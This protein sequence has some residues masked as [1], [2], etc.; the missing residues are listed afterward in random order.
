MI[1]KTLSHGVKAL[2]FSTWISVFVAFLIV[3]ITAFFVT[4]PALLEDPIENQLSKISGLSVD[5]SKITFDFEQ[6]GLVLKVHD[7][8]I[9]SLEQQVIAS[10]DSLRWKINLF[11]FRDD[12]YHPSNVNLN[13]LTIYP[14]VNKGQD[15][16]SIQDIKQLASAE[17][18]RML[19]FFQSFSI[20]KT[21]I[22]H[23]QVFEIAPMVF[24]KN[25]SNILLTVSGQRLDLDFPNALPSKVDI[26]ATFSLTQISSEQS[27]N[28]PLSINYHKLPVIE[29]NLK[30]FVEQGDDMVE[31]LG[32]LSQI[33]T[34]EV[35]QYIP[36]QSLDSDTHAWIQRGFIS[37]NLQDIELQFKKNLS[38]D[39]PVEMQFNAQ[40]KESELL[41]NADWDNLK[42]L[43]ASINTDGKKIVVT[44]N[45]TQLN[46]MQL[47]DIIV[48]ILDMSQPELDVEVI[49][50][51]NAT[52]EKFIQ[53]LR[54]AP[55]SNNI[56]ETLDQFTLTGK[57][58]G[59]LKL[60]LPLDERVSILD[61][62]LK[63][64]DNQ[65][66]T[67]NGSAVVENFNSS[68]GLH[69]NVIT[70]QGV[71]DIRGLPFSIRINPDNQ[72]ADVFSVELIHKE[73]DFNLYIAKNKNRPW[74]VN[75]VSNDFE[76]ELEVTQEESLFVVDILNF[77]MLST[78]ALEGDWNIGPEDFPKDMYVKSQNISIGAYQLPDIQVRLASQGDVLMINNLQLEGVGVNQELL[79]FNGAW[80]PG[81][82]TSLK[83]VAQGKKLSDFLNRL[84]INERTEG[85][86]FE[87][88]VRLFCQCAPWNMNFKNITG[89]I[90]MKV[91]Q[92]VFTNKDPNLGRILSL[93]N[94]RSIAKRL[95]MDVSDLTDEGFVYD[96]I[97]VRL[98]VGQSLATI[99]YFELSSTSSKIQLTGQ[100]DIVEK[101]YDLKAKVRPAIGDAIPI[102]TYLAGGGLAGLGIWLADV[103]LFKG[104]I[105]D[106]IVDEMIEFK[107]KIT[108]SWDD[109][110][111][112]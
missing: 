57:M 18:L 20:Q 98:T 80:Y 61:I 1:K 31:F 67:L 8:K 110:I 26:S 19:G 108:G 94:I 36:L 23:D 28:I 70:S 73:S 48:Q 104:K 34:N 101:T 102:A 7:I 107:Y 60:V 32:K 83:A 56:N 103:A 38:K 9:S 2:K 88:D 95:R 55:L 71:G 44:V 51:I 6:D 37:G 109:P 66:T 42:N 85:G 72:G 65:L 111:I 40:L 68:L 46:D 77:E 86:E 79:N 96:D 82:K 33:K 90:E 75:V 105:L 14:G 49:G 24:T 41:F 35:A 97:Q 17:N 81:D 22:K 63:L 58:T 45:S 43:D 78:G 12:V 4:F 92:G 13:T 106:S 16:F 69:H 99:D 62:D 21:L 5:L 53:F 89:L 54:R 52:S 15:K 59:K 84:K 25:E 27:I 10:V 76:G 11:N 100:S 3:L 112:K 74:Q 50:N 30:F 91:K 64:Q 29:A 47:N 93:L 39:A 87:F